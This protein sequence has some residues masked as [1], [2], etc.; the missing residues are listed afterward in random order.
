MVTDLFMASLWIS[1]LSFCFNKAAWTF[2]V[3]PS[4]RWFHTTVLL[5]EAWMCAQGVLETPL[6]CSIQIIPALPAVFAEL[7]RAQ[8]TCCYLAPLHVLVPVS[9]IT[10]DWASL[11]GS[12]DS[13]RGQEP[14][15]EEELCE[16][17]R[18]IPG[19]CKSEAVACQPQNGISLGI[20]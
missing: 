1:W 3:V 17:Q 12:S 7:I 11:L 15:G 20:H 18:P 19:A 5:A 16:Q 8:M 10:R 6:P 14:E 4:Q 2:K 9:C 13:S